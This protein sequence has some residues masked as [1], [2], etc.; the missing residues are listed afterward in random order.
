MIGLALDADGIHAAI[1]GD[2]GELHATSQID[3]PGP[4]YRDWLIAARDIVAGLDADTAGMEVGIGAPARLAEGRV[5]LTP[6][7]HLAGARLVADLQS[8]LCR[9][10]HVSNFAACLAAWCARRNARGDAAGDPLVALWLGG[11]CEGAIMSHGRVIDGAHGTAG[12]W[13]HLELPSPVGD[14]LE[15]RQCWC[16][17]NA[18]LETFLSTGS[19]ERDFERLTGQ[20]GTVRQ[21]EEAVERGD[22][23]AESVIQVYEDRLGRATATMIT[24]VDPEHIVIG[25]RPPLAQRLCERVPRKWPAYVRTA[26]SNIRMTACDEGHNAVIG[27][28][29]LLA[30]AAN[31]RETA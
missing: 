9:K 28:A 1:L 10:V 17:K 23:V 29:A 11:N 14:E 27:G 21:I 6:L 18:C 2:D 4:Q 26:R 30:R 16:G 5:E 12:N 13:A 19:L 15:G 7:S 22:I 25:G 20:T 8:A 31:T 24:L 3:A